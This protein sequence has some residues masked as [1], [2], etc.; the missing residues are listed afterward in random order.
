MFSLIYA[1]Q[2]NNIIGGKSQKKER[3]RQKRER[4]IRQARTEMRAREEV[5]KVRKDK[6]GPERVGVHWAHISC[7]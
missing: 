7:S 3:K 4:Q 1:Y 2:L 5:G 6:S